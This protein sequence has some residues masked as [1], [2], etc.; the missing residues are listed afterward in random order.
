MN[1]FWGFLS[2]TSPDGIRAFYGVFQKR[3]VWQ[4]ERFTGFSGLQ[5]SLYSWPHGPSG[6]RGILVIIRAWNGR[7]RCERGGVWRMGCQGG[8]GIFFIFFACPVFL[9][10]TF[11]FFGIGYW[12]IIHYWLVCRHF[13]RSVYGRMVTLNHHKDTIYNVETF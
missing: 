13:I 10:K 1:S 4:T 6:N 8:P 11:I 5:P 7:S 9:L 3:S 2:H 12:Q